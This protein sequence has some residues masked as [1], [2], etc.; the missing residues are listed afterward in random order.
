[1]DA[2][3]L[4]E[5]KLDE[6]LQLQKSSGKRLGDILVDNGFVSEHNLMMALQKKLDVPFV[7]LREQKVDRAAVQLVSEELARKYRLIPLHV[8]QDELVVATDNPLDF[9]AFEELSLVTGKQVSPV[10]AT[11]KDIAEAT[12]R[13]YAQQGAQ[14][15]LDEFNR[16]FTDLPAQATSSEDYDDMLER[17]ESAPVVRLV[18]SIVAQAVHMRASDIHIEPGET[19]VCVRFRVDGD[20]LEAMRLNLSVHISMVTRLK[21][22]SGIDIGERRVPQDGRF[23]IE[24]NGKTINMR[25]STLPTVYGEKAVLRIMGDNTLDIVSL[26]NTGIN[27]ENLRRLQTLMQNPN[28]IILVTG[29]TG[30]GKSTTI[31]AMLN[32]LST[33]NVNVVTVEDPVEKLIPG[34]S[35]VQV[36]PRAGLT[37]ASGLRSIL[38]QDPDIIMIGEIRDVETA[39]IAARAAITGHLV[40]STV[41]TN[42]AASTFM[43]LVDMGVEPYIVASSVVGV[44]SQRLVKLICPHCREEYTPDEVELAFWKEE[45]PTRFYRGRGCGRC[46]F[47]GYLGRTAIHEVISMNHEIS[48]MVLR[49][50]SAGEIRNSIR[51]TG[52]KFLSDNLTELVMEGKSTL[53]ELMRLSQHLD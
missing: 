32:Q 4:T 39:Q 20:L 44:I 49:H 30:S 34:I 43:R 28:G 53:A 7:D 12:Q 6:A 41:H 14:T 18:N 31:Y 24:I 47:T 15:A 46:N 33:P 19:N 52:G 13:Y 1:M 21:I 9:Y 29:P 17:V 38:R 51:A 5:Q 48:Q 42:D 16:E 26:K 2:G 8:H 10:L 11:K 37:F 50:A 22:L 3:Y 27:R 45:S 36:N 25:V 40:L 23:S 35:Q